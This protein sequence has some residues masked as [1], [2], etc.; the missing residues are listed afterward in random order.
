MNYFQRDFHLFSFSNTT[1][2]KSSHG[3]TI[4]ELMVAIALV[5]IISTIALPSLNHFLVKIRVDNEITE[6][7]RLLL[8][9]RN[10]AINTGKNTT[11]C[12]LDDSGHCT[13]N[14]QNKI[15]VF[16][17]DSN[18][19]VSNNSFATPDELIKVKEGVKPGDTLQFANISVIYAP[20]GQLITNNGSFNYCPKNEEDESRGV[21]LSVSGR[22]YLSADTDND[23]KDEDRNGDEIACM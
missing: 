12:P 8:T 16:T 11:I 22:S 23:G 3:F 13:S 2:L 7:Q 4:V 10:M 5:A 21:S 6:L 19:I 14:W 1:K 20:S 18:D 9:A 15:S 17:N